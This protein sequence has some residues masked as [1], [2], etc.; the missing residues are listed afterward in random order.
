MTK[1]ATHHQAKRKSRSEAVAKDRS[2][3]EEPGPK[4]SEGEKPAATPE[5]TTAVS[6]RRAVADAGPADPPVVTSSTPGVG[7]A[8]ADVSDRDAATAALRHRIP[9]LPVLLLLVAAASLFAA[10]LLTFAEAP[11]EDVSSAPATLDL[12]GFY[13]VES[14][15]HNLTGRWMSDVARIDA[16]GRGNYWIALQAVSNRRAREVL[17]VPERGKKLRFTAVPAGSAHLI[18]PVEIE[19]AATLQVS[20]RS[21]A[22]PPSSRDRRPLSVFLADLRLV[23]KPLAAFTGEGFYSRETSPQGVDFNWF[24]QKAVL[25]VV[26]ADRGVRRAWVTF[27]AL[28]ID[29]NRGKLQIRGPGGSLAIDPAL[30][31]ERVVAGPF[32]LTSGRAEVSLAVSRRGPRAGQDRRLTFRIDGIEVWD[33]PPGTDAG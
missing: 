5:D 10:Y 29:A 1:R 8:T 4:P 16:T 12:V 31:G 20:A 21:P 19:G 27:N 32:T 11:D 22:E 15:P 6:R 17:I 2:R 33:R 23:D 26:S 13:G 9:V 14:G 24:A 30:A 28:P 7:G 3:N 25:D 18:G